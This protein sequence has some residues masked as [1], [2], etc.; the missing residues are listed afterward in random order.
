MKTYFYAL[1]FACSLASPL[2]QAGGILV[3]DATARLENVY[4][5][6]KEAKQWMETAQH[7]KDQIRAY[8]DQLATAT[9]VRDIASFV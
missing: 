4:Q 7:Y 8:K 9:G 1:I 6:Q 3:F 2:V 5:W